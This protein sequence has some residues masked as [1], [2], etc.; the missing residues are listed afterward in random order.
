MT[1]NIVNNSFITFRN[2]VSDDDLAICELLKRN[3]MPGAISLSMG[4]DPSYFAGISVLGY[5]NRVAVADSN[6]GLVGLGSITSKKLYVNGMPQDIGYACNV[7]IDPRIRNIKTM[8]HLMQSGWNWSNE[9]PMGP[10]YLGSILKDN[11][12][13]FSLLT[14]SRFGIP[15]AKKLFDY[16]V[17]L[18][19]LWNRSAPPIPKEIV[20]RRGDEVNVKDLVIFLNE[21]GQTRQFYPVY[22]QDDLLNPCGLLRGL[23]LSDFL[24]ATKGDQ[25]IGSIA[26]WDQTPFRQYVVTDYNKWLGLGV[27]VLQPIAKMMGIPLPGRGDTL[28]CITAACIA[29]KSGFGGI[30]ETLWAQALHNLGGKGYT[31]IIIGFSES[32]PWLEIARQ[33]KHY[34]HVSYIVSW[35]FR[36]NVYGEY[37]LDQKLPYL[38]LGS[39]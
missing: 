29:V 36:H 19:P 37:R 21:Y 24:I 10:I 11:K 20:I 4:F 28:K 9:N 12:K 3:D 1:P 14:S 15:P 31:F 22:T 32:D 25:I 5:K 8:K 30:F 13:A 33:Y 35:D 16:E 34:R 6:V 38:E 39:L 7:R 17:L 26:L 27:S 23:S 2:A 18:T